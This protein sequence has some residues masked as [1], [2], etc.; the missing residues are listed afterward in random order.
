MNVRE[1]ITLLE[2]FVDKEVPVFYDTGLDDE[3]CYWV[4]NAY[5][6]TDSEWR[7]MNEEPVP[8]GVFLSP[9]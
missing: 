3:P 8:P 6:S 4:G 5:F 1:L 2:G 7:D 9:A